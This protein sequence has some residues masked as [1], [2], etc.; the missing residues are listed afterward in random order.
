MI[1]GDVLNGHFIKEIVQ[2]KNRIIS[3]LEIKRSNP[4]N[5]WSK[6]VSSNDLT[7]TVA[8]NIIEGTGNSNE[9]TFIAISAAG[10]RESISSTNLL[11]K[12]LIPNS[13]I[14]F[15]YKD[16]ENMEDVLSNSSLNGLAVHL[17]TLIN[18]SGKKAIKLIDFYKLTSVISRANVAK[19]MLD[20]VDKKKAYFNHVQ[21][22]AE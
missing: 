9:T 16:L 1:L 11:M 21:M 12:V 20:Q 2:D 22:I 15:A 14:R 5:P 3:C 17:V 7:T 4:F 13:N 8:K 10:V 18:G 6:L 19:R